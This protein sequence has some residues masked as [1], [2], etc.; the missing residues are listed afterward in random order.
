[1]QKGFSTP[2]SKNVAECYYNTFFKVKRGEN[3]QKLY[4]IH[5]VG[6]PLGHTQDWRENAWI[7][8]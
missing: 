6:F 8:Q 4:Q 7:Q 5:A 1:M 3:K 2:V